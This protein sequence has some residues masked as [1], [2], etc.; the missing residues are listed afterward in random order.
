M[1][2]RKRR[3]G[4]DFSKIRP[5]K[6]GSRLNMYDDTHQNHEA[7]TID[8]VQE[9]SE[10]NR[11]RAN[12][13][14]PLYDGAAC[15]PNGAARRVMEDLLRECLRRKLLTPGILGSQAG[16]RPPSLPLLGVL[17]PDLVHRA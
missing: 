15:C 13:P 8:E 9:F 7:R 2:K 16:S 12:P 17:T 3:T 4:S 10:F 1:G 11:E 6:A 14:V 5:D